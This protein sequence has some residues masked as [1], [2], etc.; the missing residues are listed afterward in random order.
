MTAAPTGSTATDLVPLADRVRYMQLF[1]V[2]VSS[3]VMLFALLAPAA[4]GVGLAPL[5]AVTASYIFLS[6]LGEFVWRL[7][8]RR[9]LTLFGAMLIC[10][11]LYLAWASY[12]TGGTISPL[13]Y[14]ILLHLVAVA[15][16]ASYRTG[17]KLA[18]WHSMLLFVVYYAQQ[19]HVLT[20]L[21]G[22]VRAQPGTEFQRLSAFVI[23]FWMVAIGTAA[24]SAVNERELRRR[25]YDLEALTV[26][27]S[28]LEDAQ[29]S[30][31]VADVLIDALVD[32]FGFPRAAVLG[33]ADHLQLLAGHGDI[34]IPGSAAAEGDSG[35]E[36]GSAIDHAQTTRRTLLLA[37]AEPAHDPLLARLL[38]GGGNLVLVPLSAEG[39]A[40][41]VLV[42]E[43]GLRSGSRIERRVVAM[44]EQFASH[45][46]LALRNAW[47]LE[48]VQGLAATDGLT[49]IANRR[50]FESILEREVA[51]AGATGE[52]MSL[53]M[54]D[55]DHFKKLNDTH[56]H[57][58]GDDVLRAVAAALTSECREFD[59][60][61]RY[62]G[63]EFAIVLPR[64]DAPKGLLMAERFRRVVARCASE[65]SV[66][67]SAGVATF[68]HHARDAGTLVRA[69]DE[70]LY[71]SKR[72]G[73]NRASQSTRWDAGRR[74]PAASHPDVVDEAAEP[75]QITPAS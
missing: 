25:K 53:I 16:L 1:R 43:H 42:A 41:G 27:A 15:L 4:L 73:R 65:L 64:C 44:V 39:R 56:G 75:N 21:T 46:A 62:G 38:P 45:A 29:T 60:A 74:V 5:A 12:A 34:G 67:A 24:F 30:G 36:P 2:A 50:T 69:A 18:L 17:M 58:R 57:Q 49:G 3:V 8:R 71:V 51:R 23:V 70:A 33:G 55:I 63:E 9:G 61:C 35:L 52:Q 11:G 68:P 14:L 54:V 19:A 6:L 40:I 28:R 37:S 72:S 10:D 47:L 22:A 48:Q 26:M 7:V 32:A 31:D 66:T 13:R 59:T 20:P